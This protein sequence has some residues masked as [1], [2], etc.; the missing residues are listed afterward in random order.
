[1]ACKAALI[2]RNAVTPQGPGLFQPWARRR[3]AYNRNV[4]T[5]GGSVRFSMRCVTAMRLEFHVT[6]FPQG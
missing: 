5:A 6:T 1:M 3:N 2:H 4:V